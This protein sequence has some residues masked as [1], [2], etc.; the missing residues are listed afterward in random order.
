MMFCLLADFPPCRLYPRRGVSLSRLSY[1]PPKTP[2]GEEAMYASVA[3]LMAFWAGCHHPA[4]MEPAAARGDKT[5]EITEQ[6]KRRFRR[7]RSPR[8]SRCVGSTV[9]QLRNYLFE[10]KARGIDNIVAPSR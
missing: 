1:F 8:T 3:E 5:L 10:A 4:P 2:A 9:D 6:V 7:A